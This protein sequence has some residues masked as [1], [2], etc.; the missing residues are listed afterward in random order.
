[1]T[2]NSYIQ[3]NPTGA[4]TYSNMPQN[5]VPSVQY[6][7]SAN[8]GYQQDNINMHPT[9]LPVQQTQIV[10]SSTGQQFVLF[11]IA[12]AS[13]SMAPTVTTTPSIHP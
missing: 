13:M 1:M 12:S 10:T 7:S 2:P 11:P 4:A 5:N 8:F 3:S 6:S 9:Q